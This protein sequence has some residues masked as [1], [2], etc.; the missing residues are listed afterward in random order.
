MERR[1]PSNPTQ[2]HVGA[3]RAIEVATRATSVA[4]HTKR[5]CKPT[6]FIR[7]L[8]DRYAA[9]LETELVIEATNPPQP[10]APAPAEQQSGD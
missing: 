2:L 5:Q 7:E 9:R 10:D 1:K 3:A 8:I 4:Y 6:D